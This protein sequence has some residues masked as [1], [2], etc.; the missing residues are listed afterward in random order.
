MNIL[1][2]DDSKDFRALARVYIHK[3]LPDAK[4]SEYEVENWV[5]QVMTSTG[6]TMMCYCW[7]II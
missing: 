3:Q 5:N 4:V 6:P 1:I 7:I 2:I